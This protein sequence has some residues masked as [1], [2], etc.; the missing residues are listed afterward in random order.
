M[1]TGRPVAALQVTDP[2][3]LHL[4]GSTVQM[5]LA[6]VFCPGSILR[7]QWPSLHQAHLPRGVH[8]PNPRKNKS[9]LNFCGLMGPT[10]GR[11]RR[12]M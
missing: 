12:A 4:G 6:L 9:D 5:P 1:E 7:V 3:G 11:N 2:G 8:S 10:A